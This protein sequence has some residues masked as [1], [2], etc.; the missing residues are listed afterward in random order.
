MFIFSLLVI[1]FLFL[2]EYVCPAKDWVIP[3]GVPVAA[4]S[5]VYIWVVGFLFIKSKLRKWYVASIAFLLSVPLTLFINN[6]V[7]VFTNEPQSTF[8]IIMNVISSIG[9]ALIFFYLG[10]AR[11]KKTAVSK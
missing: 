10:Y 1:P 6:T 3:L 2:I 7:A 11:K 5:L 8:Q 4:A 9:V